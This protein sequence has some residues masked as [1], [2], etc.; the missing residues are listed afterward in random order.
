MVL[1]HGQA[2]VERGF[3]INKE[4]SVENLTERSFIAQ[5]VIK[6]AI[7]SAGGV[8]K[9]EITKK[10]LTQASSARA[11]YHAYLE[12]Q[13]KIREKSQLQSKRKNI[14]KDISDLKTKKARLES[15]VITLNKN[16]SKLSE[17]AEDAKGF[18]KLRDYV[19]K[20]NSFRRTAAEKSTLAKQI[21]TQIDE[22]LN[23]LKTIL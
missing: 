21:D 19:V 14:Q 13:K 15:D 7:S 1:S 20:A 17:E 3:S 10:L 8:I 12:D 4:L 22:K 2:T 23:E 16:A 6:D 9:I 5:R 18:A 11:K